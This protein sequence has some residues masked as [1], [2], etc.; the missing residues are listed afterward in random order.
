MQVLKSG[1]QLPIV[2][3]LSHTE[4]WTKDVIESRA[5]NLLNL[6]W[7]EISPWLFE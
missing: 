3:F 6:V 7:D 4:E 2:G 5:V 1:N